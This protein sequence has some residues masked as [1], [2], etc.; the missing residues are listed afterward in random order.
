[1]I[2][3]YLTSVALLCA[4]SALFVAAYNNG[5]GAEPPMGWNTWCTDDI[6]GLIDKCS[7]DLV[8]KEAKALV[9][10]GMKDLGYEYVNMDDCWSAKERTADGQLQ[11]DPDRFPS[12]MKALADYVHS[13]GLK[14][15][16]YTCIG[17]HTCRNGLP[18]SFGH[19]EQDAKT[20]AGWGI[21]FVKCDNCN[22]PGQYTEEQL[23]SNF[24]Y[25]LNATGRPILFSLCEWGDQ[26][27][28]SW[29]S[30]VA[31]MY[32]IQ[33][34]HLPFWWL[35]TH[36]AGQ[37]FGQGSLNIIDYIGTLKPSTFVRPF[38][39]MDPD[40]LMTLF[41]LTMPYQYSRAEFSMWSMWSSPL[42]VATSVHNM[43]E[44]KRSILMNKE[45]IA[46]NKDP[47]F[48]AADRV[49][50]DNVTLMQVWSRPLANGDVVLVVLNGQLLFEGG[51]N[52]TISFQWVDVGLTQVGSSNG[53]ATTSVTQVRD[54]WAHDTVPSLVGSTNVTVTVPASDLVMWRVSCSA[55]CY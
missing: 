4:T 43:T 49:L 29:G 14:I 8:K 48:I 55:S 53:T 7:E 12:G 28:Q 39:W 11:P 21:D 30:N 46:I 34:D 36:A 27:V 45:V 26:D 44:E 5:V 25:Y 33:M 31:Q 18:G 22:R 13:L 32:R 41:P 42:I 47:L 20:L 3:L 54:L 37:G 51:S 52:A 15:G 1:M 10:S 40:F 19:Y 24:S 23:Y 16:V 50:N 6:C 38:G 2:R 35:T 9:D 17:T